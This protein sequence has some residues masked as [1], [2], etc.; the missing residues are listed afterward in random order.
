[1][2]F[3]ALQAGGVNGYYLAS[4]SLNDKACYKIFESLFRFFFTERSLYNRAHSKGASTAR[5]SA[6]ASVIR[7]AVDVFLRNL[8]SRSVRA[9]I[10]HVTDFLM[11]PSDGLL[12]VLCVD[13]TKCL[14]SILHYPPHLEHLGTSEWKKILDSCLKIINVQNDEES[15]LLSSSER[16]STLD[17]YLASDRGSTP[18]RMTPT[19]PVRERSK[20]NQSAI[21]EA[22]TCIQLL[23]TSSNAPIQDHFD[24]VLRSLAKFLRPYHIP[25]ATHQAAI[26]SINSVV[27]KVMFDQTEFIRMFLLDLIPT[28]QNLWTTKLAG[29]KDGLLVTLM[30]CLII[31]TDTVKREPSESL[32]SIIE[33]LTDVIFS[34]Y[35]KRPDKEILQI[36]EVTFYQTTS[37]HG[38]RFSVWPR[39]ESPKSEHN[40]TTIW[41]ISNFMKLSEE[42]AAC[43]APPR[44]VGEESTKKP[45]PKSLIEDVHRDSVLASGT[46][47]LCAL[48][49][50]PFVSGQNVSVES[51]TSLLHRLIPNI[52]DDNGMVSSWTM[53]AIARSVP[54]RK[55]QELMTN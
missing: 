31:L 3:S 41:I 51:K 12:D 26:R 21:G 45:R 52:L 35:T 38:E 24:K 47:K 20:G 9:I 15:S 22:V 37:D 5:L 32:A 46:R 34:E 39:P 28:I 33:S 27:M 6:C 49:M 36:D 29:L 13:Y 42:I 17:G 11:V 55:S 30:L 43:L 23:T 7:T 44:V 8:R 2:L 25:G 48:Q 54:M 19:L 14:T 50:I 1:M 18:S 4:A 16:R 53:I 40:W 10:D